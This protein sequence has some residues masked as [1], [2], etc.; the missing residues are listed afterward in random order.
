MNTN[1]EDRDPYRLDDSA[2][3]RSFDRAVAGYDAAAIVQ[4]IVRDR[5]LERLDDVRVKPRVI[6]DAGSGT[7]HG[8]VA[9]LKRY[10]GSRVVALDLALSMARE[11]RRRR[12]LL[13]RLDAVCA[14]TAAIPLPDASVDLIHSNLM[15]QWCNDLDEVL[16]EFLRVLTPGGLL[17]F[18]TFGPDTLTELRRS[19]QAADGKVHVNRFIDMHDIGDA[20]VRVGFAEPVMDVDRICTTY[21]CLTDLMRDLK[22]IGAH[23]VTAGRNRGLTGRRRLQAAERAYEEFRR[24]SRLPATWEVIYGQGWKPLS[25]PDRPSAAGEVR[26][27]VASIGRRPGSD[28]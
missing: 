11:S 1:P 19:W 8:G 21:Q 7:G 2:V 17:T 9:L 14:D 16:S 27:P 20:A 6:L 4:S 22:A 23:N 24:D 10:R 26:I 18:T 15:L 25:A 28:D 5:L 3:R 13:R 12:P